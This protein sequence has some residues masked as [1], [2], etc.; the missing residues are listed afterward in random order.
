MS[1]GRRLAGHLRLGRKSAGQ[2]DILRAPVTWSP[3]G[4]AV[5]TT[6]VDQAVRLGQSL[7]VGGW[8]SGNAGYRLAVAGAPVPTRAFRTSRPR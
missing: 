4:P 6:K 1:I 3:G 2:P 7:I 5:V 8:S